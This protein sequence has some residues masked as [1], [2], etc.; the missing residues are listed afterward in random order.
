VTS[1]AALGPP[2]DPRAAPRPGR[3]VLDGRDV[4]IEPLDPLRHGESLFASTG[5]PEHEHLWTYMFDGPFADREAFDRS[6][7]RLAVSDDPLY[8]AIVDR[9]SRRAVGRA[10]LMR[11][12]PA[13]RVIEVGGI[14]YSPRLQRTRGATEAMYLLAQYVFEGLGYRRYEWKCNALN[15]RSRS[16]A[17]R[18]G[19]TFEGIFRQHLIIKERSRDTAWFSMLDSEWPDRKARFQRWLAPENFDRD[20]HQLSPMSGM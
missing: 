4:I 1:H 20:G 6:L 18:L 5:R 11:I 17:L 14:V 9:A 7:A 19:F 8:S 16:A 3:V 2:V 12:E 15:E 10:A 13:H